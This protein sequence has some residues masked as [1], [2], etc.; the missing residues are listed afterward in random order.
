M[1][2]TYEIKTSTWETIGN[3][4]EEGEAPPGRQVVHLRPRKV[5]R[6]D[7]VEVLVVVGPLAWENGQ[8]MRDE[9]PTK[10]ACSGIFGTMA[11][12]R[13]A[14]QSERSMSSST[15]TPGARDSAIRLPQVHVR[16]VA[17]EG[18]HRRQVGGVEVRFVLH[19]VLAC[20]ET[21]GSS[22][23]RIVDPTTALVHSA[24]ERPFG[25]SRS[26]CLQRL[27]F[28]PGHPRMGD[29][30]SISSPASG[31]QAHTPSGEARCIFVRPKGKGGTRA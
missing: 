14:I 13:S 5:A 8:G 15:T 27:P 31:S 11:L 6:V 2:A 30:V 1:E 24:L 17:P 26:L 28:S 19:V 9:W 20:T 22:S 21:R 25:W 16:Q 3:V 7:P 18:P 4:A 10:S 12:K 23:G 29:H